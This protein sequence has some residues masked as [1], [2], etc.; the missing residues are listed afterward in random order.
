VFVL[1]PRE[2]HVN[3]LCNEI[4]EELL[5]AGASLEEML[6]ELRRMREAGGPVS[7]M[8]PHDNWYR[9]RSQDGDEMG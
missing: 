8:P 5:D 6:D 7:G 1:S 9:E 2:S 4:R 3:A